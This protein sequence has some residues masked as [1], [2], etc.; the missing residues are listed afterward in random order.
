VFLVQGWVVGTEGF[1]Q[2]MSNAIVLAEVLDVVWMIWL[3]V[4]AWRMQDEPP[5]R[6]LAG[7]GGGHPGA[8]HTSSR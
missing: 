8:R 6:R 4:V 7:E 5:S 1:S 3:V 2:T